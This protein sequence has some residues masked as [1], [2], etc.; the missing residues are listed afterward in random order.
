VTGVALVAVLIAGCGSSGGSEGDD[1]LVLRFLGFDSSNITQV[2]KVGP[3][4][5][6]IDVQQDLCTTGGTSTSTTFEPFENAR[7]NANFL[8]MQASNMYINRVRIDFGPHSGLG[9]NGVRDRDYGPTG[10]L[11]PGGL[12]TDGTTACGVNSDCSG[13]SSTGTTSTCTHTQAAVTGLMLIDVD[14][15]YHISP[16]IIGQTTNVTITFF[17]DDDTDR[18]FQLTTHYDIVFADYDNCSKTT[19]GG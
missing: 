1:R 14:D 13:T 10:V 4:S 5:A 17:A 18:S 19:G 8:N 7:I 2:D 9:A 15:K 3:T 16:D 11:I 12:C 6:D